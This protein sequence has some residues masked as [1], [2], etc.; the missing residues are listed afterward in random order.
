MS[1]RDI[2]TDDPRVRVRPGKGSRPR[3]KIRPD[4][5]DARRGRVLRIDRGRYHVRMLDDGVDVVAVKARELGRGKLAVGDVVA[6]VGDLTG[7][8]DTLAR[9]AAIDE[10]TTVLRRTAEEG[11]ASG[12]ER[13]IV[14]NADQLVIVT[15][16]AQPEPR[17]GM[18]D[19]CLVAA[20]DAG[21]TPIL[22][23]TKADL[24]DPAELLALYDAL[25]LQIL[26]SST[27]PVDPHADLTPVREALTGHVSV[28]VGHS[29]VGKSTL[30]N[31]LVEGA[32][33]ETGH[34]NE[35]TGRGRHTS[36]SAMAFDFPGGAIIDT[37]GVRTFGL[38]HVGPNDLLRGFPDLEAIAEEACPRGCTHEEGAIDCALSE[39]S[40]PRLVARVASFRRL[41]EA[42]TGSD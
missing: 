32:G 23:L 22:M 17:P 1:R 7:T 13:I 19:R 16:L 38:A 37:P 30:L 36:T 41:L 27:A 26:V 8:K 15:A 40:E 24:A 42:K 33:R 29:G 20:Y 39:V 21:M 31:A 9:I 5:S 3:T 2:G 6:M 10:R 4:Y 25:D 11:E 14:A 28:L 18:I 12:T 35:V 34:V